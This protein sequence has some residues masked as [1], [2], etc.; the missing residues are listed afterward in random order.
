MT[1]LDPHIWC[2]NF[3]CWRF[4]RGSFLLPQAPTAS[5]FNPRT[6]SYLFVF[7]SIQVF[8]KNSLSRILT[9]CCHPKYGG[10][11]WSHGHLMLPTE[12]SI[13]IFEL[14]KNQCHVMINIPLTRHVLVI[15]FQFSCSNK[16]IFQKSLFSSVQFMCHKVIFIRSNRA[17]WQLEAGPFRSMIYL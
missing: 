2:A 15:T 5:M 17:M 6:R 3:W 7:Y 11:M 12:I 9:I 16:S 14:V 10:A 4:H 13:W 1:D 8:P